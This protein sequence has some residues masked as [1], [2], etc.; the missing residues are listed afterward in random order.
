MALLLA[1][2]PAV[3]VAIYHYHYG[4][5]WVVQE[6]EGKGGGK[7]KNLITNRSRASL[8]VF[9]SQNCPSVLGIYILSYEF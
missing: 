4:I 3:I 1:A 2:I 7:P 5:A 9:L 8:P 6:N